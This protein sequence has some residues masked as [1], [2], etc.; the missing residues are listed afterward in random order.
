MSRPRITAVVASLAVASSSLFAPSAIAAPIIMAQQASA[1]PVP[2]ILTKDNPSFTYTPPLPDGVVIT[3]IAPDETAAENN[4]G[5]LVGVLS[6]DSKSFTISLNT[7]T[8]LTGKSVNN[9]VL[10]LSDGNRIPLS[11]TAIYTEEEEPEGL[12]EWCGSYT[13]ITTP[14]GESTE[15]FFLDVPKPE[16]AHFYGGWKLDD[17]PFVPEAEGWKLHPTDDPSGKYFTV[18]VPQSVDHGDVATVAGLEGNPCFEVEAIDPGVVAPEETEKPEPKPD[19]PTPGTGGIPG[20]GGALSAL[21]GVG[22]LAALAGGLGS[23]SAGSS[24]GAPADPQPAPKADPQPA[25]AA[26]QKGIDPKAAK[27]A[28]P[29]EGTTQPTAVRKGVLAN[30][31]TETV[32]ATLAGGVIFAALGAMLLAGRRRDF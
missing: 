14:L 13:L 2:S 9:W 26:P 23:S 6:E 8:T 7:D 18:L 1:I 29:A 30:T 25:P 5:K 15:P 24:S 19:E 31:G 28:K 16:D 11:I 22:A 3:A 27:P 12:P 20:G 21:L 17:N 10:I 4:P 32:L